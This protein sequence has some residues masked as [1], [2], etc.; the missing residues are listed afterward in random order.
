MREVDEFHVD[1][2]SKS[3][4]QRRRQA[5]T[6]DEGAALPIAAWKLAIV[7]AM[8]YF[9]SGNFMACWHLYFSRMAA[10]SISCSSYCLFRNRSRGSPTSVEL[11][12]S[13][14][15]AFCVEMFMIERRS[16]WSFLALPYHDDPL[17]EYPATA[18]DF[19]IDILACRPLAGVMK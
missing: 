15:Y 1:H 8:A 6:A 12:S 2:A 18:R 4:M 19:S 16:A 17:C 14:G 13:G 10:F 5:A 3:S 7:P 9:S 11:E